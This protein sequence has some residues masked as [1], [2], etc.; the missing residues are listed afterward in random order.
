W[1]PLV[2]FEVAFKT[3][4]VALGALGA[5]WIVGPLIASTGHAAVTNTEIARFLVAPAGIAYLVLIAL[6]L[7]LATLIE[8]VGVIAIAATPLRG[9]AVTVREPLAA[10]A[11]VSLRLFTFGINSLATLAFLCAP[12]AV[13]GGLAYL[14][15]LSRH[16]INYY[17]SNR[18]PNFYAAAAI[19]G[20]LLAG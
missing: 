17:L 13:V 12:F 1:R 7:M 10:L 6:A 20:V 3:A 18:P 4:V 15:L 16:D 11:A 2:A 14:A 19:G 8:H 5:G 9:R